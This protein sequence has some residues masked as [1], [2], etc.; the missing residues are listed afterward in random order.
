LS[1]RDGSGTCV[2][3]YRRRLQEMGIGTL[4]GVRRL[5]FAG[6][7]RSDAARA[8]SAATRMWSVVERRFSPRRRRRKRPGLPGTGPPGHERLLSAFGPILPAARPPEVP[9]YAANGG[10]FAHRGR[11]LWTSKRAVREVVQSHV[12]YVV[13]GLP[14]TGR[15]AA[16]SIFTRHPGST[17]SFVQHRGAALLIPVSAQR[18]E[19]RRFPD[20]A[21]RWPVEGTFPTSARKEGIRPADEVKKVAAQ[22]WVAGPHARSYGIGT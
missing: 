16:A 15:Q 22:R 12:T 2:G 6:T 14:S 19:A 11:R 21:V 3:P 20:F 10:R 18:P 9:V 17:T 7:L 13:A 5:S 8:V 1:G 4:R